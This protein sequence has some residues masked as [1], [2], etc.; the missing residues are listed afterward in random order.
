MVL[1]AE[2]L[3]DLCDRVLVLAHDNGIFILPEHEVILIPVHAVEHVLL[4]GQIEARIMALAF[5][6]DHM[7]IAPLTGAGMIR[8]AVPVRCPLPASLRD[9]D[10]SA[11]LPAAFCSHRA[12]GF[13]LLYRIMDSPYS[14]QMT[15]GFSFPY[16][17]TSCSARRLYWN[18]SFSGSGRWYRMSSRM[19]S[20]SKRIL[21]PAALL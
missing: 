8:P 19:E 4:Q 3:V 5:D 11:H 16:F 15:A 1:L 10:R 12:P 14:C 21:R 6:I 17:R 13:V 9:T 20:C 7:C 2:V 18:R